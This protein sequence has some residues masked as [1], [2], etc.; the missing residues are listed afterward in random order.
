M[1]WTW[2]G[3]LVL[4]H[5]RTAAARQW[6]LKRMRG[7]VD[8]LA[9]SIVCSIQSVMANP[10]Q[11]PYSHECPQLRSSR[12]QSNRAPQMAQLAA[13]MS[14]VVAADASSAAPSPLRPAMLAGW[15]LSHR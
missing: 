12:G 14:R 4:L 2:A 9:T 11:P 13:S 5:P 8:W 6:L 1:W 10:S 3:C 7:C 15:R